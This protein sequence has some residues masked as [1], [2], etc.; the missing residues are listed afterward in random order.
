MIRNLLEKYPKK[1]P[2]LPTELKKKIKKLYL[3]NRTNSLSVNV[4]E[5]WGHFKIKSKIADKRI[6]EIGPGTLNHIPFESL[7]KKKYDVV[8]PDDNFY[9]NSKVSD[10]SKINKRYLDI[11]EIKKKRYD[12]IISCYVLEHLVDLPFIIAKTGLL[13]KKNGT[14]KHAIPCE[15]CFA[16]T[17][18]RF[19]HSDIKFYLQTGYSNSTFM[20]YEHVNN[21]EEIKKIS[22]FFFNSVKIEFSY[23]LFLDKHSS[24]YACLTLKNPVLN[25]CKNYLKNI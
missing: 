22:K 7:K 15:G 8:E 1:R 20:K 12:T 14:S 13:L 3:A 21:F 10:R 25:R 16:W 23:P 2:K 9:L 5:K 18:G 4:F 17:I 24:F 6:L 19:I 11:R